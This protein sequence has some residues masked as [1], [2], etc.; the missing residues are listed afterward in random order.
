MSKT[1]PL[2]VDSTKMRGDR[3]GTQVEVQNIIL[4]DGEKLFITVLGQQGQPMNTELEPMDETSYGGRVLLKHLEGISYQ[5]VIE[6]GEARLFHSTIKQARAEHA[7]V[8]KWEPVMEEVVSLMDLKREEIAASPAAS[9]PSSDRKWIS[10]A[11]RT[12]QS[13]LEK[14]DL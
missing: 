5:F 10:D 4:H 13:L 7:L 8:D 12:G 2:F 11:A 14:W 9:A 6:A 1:N 3:I